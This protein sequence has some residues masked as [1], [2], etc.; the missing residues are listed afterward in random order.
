MDTLTRITQLCGW[1]DS[2]PIEYMSRQLY[3]A[4]WRRWERGD[5]GFSLY[6][7]F[8]SEDLI[9]AEQ[10]FEARRLRTQLRHESAAR[11]GEARRN[12]HYQAVIVRDELASM[13]M[14]IICTAGISDQPVRKFTMDSFA[15]ALTVE[16][17]QRF[18]ARIRAQ[19]ESSL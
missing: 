16:E 13:E 15:R 14:W 4:G 8:S 19:A 5:R 9:E 11:R 7:T 6:P 12:A 1:M 10:T 2:P 18:V 3:E 17:K